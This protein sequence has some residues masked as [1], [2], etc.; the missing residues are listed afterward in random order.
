M[1]E[2]P[3]ADAYALGCVMYELV[4]GDPL[5]KADTAEELLVEAEELHDAL[6]ELEEG[7]D[8]LNLGDLS[9]HGQ[10]VLSG[11]LQFFD[12]ERLT[13]ADALKHPWFTESPRTNKTPEED[14][15]ASV[16]SPTRSG[17]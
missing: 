8:G 1:C 3:A 7:Y 6:I 11:L 10:Q 4:T 12:C 2:G 13:A 15:E 14:P 17:S 16:G 5:F 9:L